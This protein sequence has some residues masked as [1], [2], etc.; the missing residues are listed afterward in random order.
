MNE[1]PKRDYE[2]DCGFWDSVNEEQQINLD[3]T[4][5]EIKR[6]IIVDL[7]NTLNRHGLHE[8][9][10]ELERMGWEAGAILDKQILVAVND[11]NSR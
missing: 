5:E 11:Q 2:C 10:A 7:V 4:K 8:M 6:K 3:E 9:L 1:R